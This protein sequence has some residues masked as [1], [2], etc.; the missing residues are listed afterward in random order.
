MVVS[1]KPQGHQRGNEIHEP[2]NRA[3]KRFPKEDIAAVNQRLAQVDGDPRCRA[4]KRQEAGLPDTAGCTNRSFVSD[5]VDS[6]ALRPDPRDRAGKTIQSCVPMIQMFVDQSAHVALFGTRRGNSP[7]H[8]AV[9]E[10]FSPPLSMTD[11][12]SP[13]SHETAGAHIAG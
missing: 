2:D 9:A 7:W 8:L 13:G 1:G 12:E 10:L 5:G 3:D 4:G 6:G 11:L